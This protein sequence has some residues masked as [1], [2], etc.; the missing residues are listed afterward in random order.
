M[1]LG[2]T[3]VSKECLVG[4]ENLCGGTVVLRGQGV[5]K[6]DVMFGLLDGGGSCFK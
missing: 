3:L 5:R 4:G 1:K 6:C 2:D